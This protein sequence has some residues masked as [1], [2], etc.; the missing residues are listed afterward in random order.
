MSTL[1]LPNRERRT[2]LQRAYRVFER[3]KPQLLS[4]RALAAVMS[5]EVPVAYNYI[6]RLKALGCI[7]QQGGNARTPLYG[8]A[9]G[10]TMPADDARGR[11]PRRLL[12][13][14]LEP[15]ISGG[16]HEELE[17]GP[18]AVMASGTGRQ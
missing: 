5:I 14:V 10:A 1:S 2:H 13:R 15:L 17:F 7:R 6:K 11:K 3:V 4:A 18:V 12:T 8:L 16:A 9:E